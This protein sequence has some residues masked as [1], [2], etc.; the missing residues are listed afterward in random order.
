MILGCAAPCGRAKPKTAGAARGGTIMATILRSKAPHW[1]YAERINRVE[2]ADVQPWFEQGFKDF[3]A[4]P[5]ASFGYGLLFAGFGLALAW[6]IWNT[7]ALYLLAPLSCG[8]LLLGPALTVGFQAISRDLE[9]GRKPSLFSALGAW[10]RD[11]P[12]IL[13]LAALLL[14]V[15]LVWMRLAQLLYALVFPP[16]AGPDLDSLATATFTTA[17]GLEFLV[18]FCLLGAAFAG[19]VFV[20]GAFALQLML[21]RK[22]GLTEA[23]LTSVAAVAMNPAPMALWAALLAG[24]TF[25]GMA[26]FYLG[27]AVTLPL[28]GHAAWRAY[29][30][31]IK[32]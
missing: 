6:A 29:R 7:D 4:A 30:A 23:V 14:G 16:L 19:V 17:G 27:L 24:L 22:A 10:R 1:L 18:L 32:P 21:D 2:L 15:F 28:A 13:G 12:A 20:G 26:F 5:V 8:F 25:A 3:T 31:V 9:Q 11:A